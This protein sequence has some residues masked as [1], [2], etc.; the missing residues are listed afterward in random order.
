MLIF[1]VTVKPAELS[2]DWTRFS[3][4]VRRTVASLTRQ[5]SPAYRVVVV[6]DTPPDDALEHPN[7]DYLPVRLPIPHDWAT[8]ENDKARRLLAG[9]DFARGY[10]PTHVM[11]V[12]ADDVVSVRLAAFVARNPDTPGWVCRQGYIWPSGR[13]VVLRERRGFAELCGSSLILGERIV[14]EFFREESVAFRGGL[15]LPPGSL[16]FDH[17]RTQLDSGETLAS[18]PFPGAVYLV[19]H[20]ENIRATRDLVRERFVLRSIAGLPAKVLRRPPR[21]VTARFR[22]EF[23]LQP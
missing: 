2:E 8:M 22:Q 4:M 15:R 13:P 9:I 10:R 14:G 3:A 23:G 20:G 12:D 1:V 17:Q 21:L 19:L 7:V 18:L 6:H 5:T 11:A 16:W